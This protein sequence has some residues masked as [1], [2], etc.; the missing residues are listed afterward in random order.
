MNLSKD[1][2]VMLNDTEILLEIH[3]RGKD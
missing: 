1:K 3:R 2:G